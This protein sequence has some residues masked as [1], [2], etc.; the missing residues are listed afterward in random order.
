MIVELHTHSDY[1]GGTHDV[2]QMLAVMNIDALAIT[3]HDTFAGYYAAKK[4]K[5][6]VLLVPGIEVTTN[7]GHVLCIGIEELKFE[8]HCNAFELVDAVHESGGIAIAAHPFRPGESLRDMNLLAKVDAVEVING[9]TPKRHN[10]M[11]LRAAQ[12][13]KKPKTSGSDAHRK[14]DIGTYAFIANAHSIDGIV[15]C[16]KKDKLILPE[17]QP[18]LF[19]LGV[20][21]IDRRF[22]LAKKKIFG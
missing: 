10:L 6:D 14:K 7:I 21:V 16:I 1:S 12:Q 19:S 18:T 22:S 15:K 13:H 17:K 2:K 8:K 3:D 4:L 5:K 20:K 11:A 9:D